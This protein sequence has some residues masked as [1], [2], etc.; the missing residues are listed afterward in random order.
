MV[1][2]FETKDIAWYKNKAKQLKD[3]AY[4]LEG[5]HSAGR[6]YQYF[7]KVVTQCLF[8]GKIT[9]S[10]KVF[11]GFINK[12]LIVHP[13]PN[14]SEVIKVRLNLKKGNIV[15]IITPEH[16]AQEANYLF[17]FEDGIVK[18]ATEVHPDDLSMSED[19]YLQIIRLSDLKTHMKDDQWVD[20]GD[21]KDMEGMSD[22]DQ[23]DSSEDPSLSDLEGSEDD[24]L[25][26]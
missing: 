15:K 4:E 10:V 12:E 24:H 3:I 9:D 16:M 7:R 17:I 8:S 22:S 25:D 5:S 1:D 14:H 13:K 6:A 11:G 20:L 23:L 18:K 26:Y 19:G 2:N 21:V